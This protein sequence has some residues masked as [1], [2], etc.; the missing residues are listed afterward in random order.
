M[1]SSELRQPQQGGEQAAD[2]TSDPFLQDT[3]AGSLATFGTV[4]TKSHH[5]YFVPR[6][7]KYK[8][9]YYYTEKHFCISSDI[10]TRTNTFHPTKLQHKV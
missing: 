1:A 4:V 6:I 8:L 9:Y 2:L 5:L 7:N 3:L 10:H